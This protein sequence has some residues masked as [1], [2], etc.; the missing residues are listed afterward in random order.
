VIT[1]RGFTPHDIVY[2]EREEYNGSKIFQLRY[3]AGRQ[4][5]KGRICYDGELLLEYYWV[6]PD[7]F[8]TQDG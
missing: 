1:K 7:E 5:R 3:P 2:E 8:I 6:I 4:K